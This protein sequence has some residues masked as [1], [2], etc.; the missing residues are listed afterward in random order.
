[1][2][3]ENYSI[4]GLKDLLNDLENLSTCLMTL[5]TVPEHINSSV[6]DQ[7]QEDQYALIQTINGYATMLQA[8]QSGNLPN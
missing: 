7:L 4:I 5:T 6:F 8:I 3:T 1:M 2:T